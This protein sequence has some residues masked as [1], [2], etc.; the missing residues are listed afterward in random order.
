[1]IIIGGVGY[2]STLS[3]VIYRLDL[4]DFSMQ[5]LDASGVGPISRTLD[6][7]AEMIYEP[8]INI[9]T[10]EGRVYKLRVRDMR[11]I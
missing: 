7:T 3:N 11:W 5:Q 6:H 1:M 2:S 10:T 8:I 9:T 4:T